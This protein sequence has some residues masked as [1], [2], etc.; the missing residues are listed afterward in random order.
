MPLTLTFDP[1][2]G[3]G[4][5]AGPRFAA[6]HAGLIAAEGGRLC[7]GKVGVGVSVGVKF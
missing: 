7:G 3:L 1:S 6:R 5:G 4:V 2:G